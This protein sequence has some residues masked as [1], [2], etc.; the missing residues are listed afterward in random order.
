MDS[1]PLPPCGVYVTTAPIGE[2]PAG[3]LVYFHN[4]GNPGPG[5]YLP[6]GWE[7]N[8]AQWHP[9]GT[10]LPDEASASTLEPLPAEGLYVVREPFHCCDKRCREFTVDQLVQLGYQGTGQALLFE[11]RWVGARLE[12]PTQNGNKVDRAR[13]A[14]LTQ[15]RVPT[16]QPAAQSSGGGGEVL[17]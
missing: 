15:L 14:K 7:L 1:T 16:A 8:R 9:T 10:T 3:R 11:P 5:I 4:H 13:L 2:V 17:H 12:L 6:R